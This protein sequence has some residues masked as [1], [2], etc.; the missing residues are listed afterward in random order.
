MLKLHL[1]K[2]SLLSLIFVLVLSLAGHSQALNFDM[3]KDLVLVQY[4]FRT[5]VDDLHT[6]A[7]FATILAHPEYANLNY[8]AVAGTYGIQEGLYVPP[9]ELMQLAFKNKWADAHGDLIN[10]IDKV[11]EKVE[12]SL[13]NGGA[14]WVAEAGQSDFTAQWL[15]KLMERNP[16]INSEEKIHVVQHSDWNESVTRSDYLEDVKN[17]TNYH[18]IP[19]GNQV[20]NGTPG[21]RSERPVNWRSQVEDNELISIWETAIRIGT[22]YNGKDK[23]YLNEA[24]ANGGLDFSDLSEVCYILNRSNITDADAFFPTFAAK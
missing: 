20:G 16:N 17:H 8:F 19:D 23:R 5:D 1:K 21:F 9:N 10:A 12:K 15:N 24:I 3:E 11:V 18:K 22:T 4:D 6:V 7:G 2:S 14:I 13:E